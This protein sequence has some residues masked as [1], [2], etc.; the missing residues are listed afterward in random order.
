SRTDGRLL[1]LNRSQRQ[2]LGAALAAVDGEIVAVNG[3]PGTGKTT[4]IQSLVASLWVERA[5]ERNG[6]PPVILAS[7]TNNRAI[8]NILDTFARATL[9]KTHPLAGLP[10]AE[11]WL[12][13]FGQYGL[14]LP[15]ISEAEKGIKDE[16]AFAWCK[17]H[18]QPWKGLPGRM[19]NAAY[20]NRA[21]SYWQSRFALWSGR[22]PAD[23]AQ[24]VETLRAALS[25]KVEALRAAC[26]RH[27][28]LLALS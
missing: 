22:Q 1:P 13:D 20:V 26:G 24:A 18:G 27:R 19:E 12:P 11:R 28:D 4:F 21:M 2:S 10:L 15:S 5:L 6:E 8:T 14:Y 7:S 23:M 16:L 25:A 9:P 3:P 17:T